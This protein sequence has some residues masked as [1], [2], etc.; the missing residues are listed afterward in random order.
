MQKI[1]TILY[2]TLDE[3]ISTCKAK[4]LS[5]SGGLDSTIIACYLKNKKINGISVI[6]KDFVATDLTYCQLVAKKFEIP[7]DLVS[8]ETEDL[9]SAIEETVKILKIFNNIEIRNSVVMY[10]VL[11]A[12]KEKGESKVITGDGADEL[13]AGYNFF[14]KKNEKQLDNDLN[15]IWSLMHFPTKK[16]GESLGISVESPFLMENM[17]KFA[18]SLPVNL[19]VKEEN[20]KKFGKWILRKAFEKKIPQTIAWRK[21][22]PM[23]DGAGTTALTNLFE[24]LIPDDVFKKRVKELQETDKVLIQ[25]KESLHYYD[26]YKKYCLPPYKLHSSSIKCPNCQFSVESNTKFCRMCGSYPI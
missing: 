18:K 10:L 9:L 4:Y 7:L 12:L 26:I 20:G 8:I 6:M 17:V 19:K 15:R 5:L 16:I 21:K 22:S 14:L 23:Q 1:F 2:D 3:A 24:I 13:F 11:S 25:S